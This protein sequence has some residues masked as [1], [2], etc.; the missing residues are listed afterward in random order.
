VNSIKKSVHL[1]IYKAVQSCLLLANLFINTKFLSINDFAIYA[2]TTSIIVIAV[3]LSKFGITVF[4]LRNI[5]YHAKFNNN[6][7]INY[8]IN[9]SIK[10][11]IV[12]AFIVDCIAFVIWLIFKNFKPE[13]ILYEN[14]LQVQVH[15][16]L[17]LL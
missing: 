17:N 3:V 7:E 6:E 12:Q 2:I 10:L 9:K 14:I 4:L 11:I 8:L 15:A 16:E 5:S 13:I 1:L